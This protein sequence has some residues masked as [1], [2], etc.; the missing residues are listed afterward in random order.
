MKDSPAARLSIGALARATGIAVETL[1]TWETRYGF[2]APERKP[3]G[4]RVYPLSCVPR[5]KR[6]SQALARGHRA[7][8]VVGA[9]E[10]ALLSLLQSSGLE[11]GET[12]SLRPGPVGLDELVRL[13]EALAAE[14][15]T[16]LLLSDF[17]RLGVLACLEQRVAPLLRAVGEAWAAGRLGVRHEHFV[18][19]R[20]GDLLR[21]LRLPYDESARGA[22]VVLATLPDEPHEL[23]LLMAALTVAAAGGRVLYLGPGTPPQEMLSMVRDTGAI[24]LGVSVSAA[25]AGA[26]TNAQIRRLRARLPRRVTLLV[27]GE[28]AP[29]G[30]DGVESLVELRKLDAWARE[31]QA[32]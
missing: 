17:A 9:S 16:R 26:R 29:P 30:R 20:I 7:G 18:S 8:Q 6:I 5:L 13:V 23:G 22:L 25:S 24:A 15:L 2:P 27:G 11:P 28:G 4:H 3:S 31:T 19:E 12:G 10:K 14:R 21:S 1:R 32:S